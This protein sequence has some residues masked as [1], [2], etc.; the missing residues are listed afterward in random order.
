MP[1]VK[2]DRIALRKYYPIAD[3]VIVISFLWA[4]VFVAMQIF[5]VAFLSTWASNVETNNI[6]ATKF[7]KLHPGFYFVF[8]NFC[9]PVFWVVNYMPHE[10]ASWIA[11]ALDDVRRDYYDMAST[12]GIV[13]LHRHIAK[14]ANSYPN[15]V[16]QFYDNKLYVYSI[17]EAII[18]VS[19]IVYGFITR[20]ITKILYH[21]L[22]H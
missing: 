7:L 20:V 4:N 9:Y 22:G 16:L 6:T 1:I 3:I 13:T 10:I 8:Q 2:D 18:C 15:L 5:D 12:F 17:G 14:F 11:T 21:I 19:A